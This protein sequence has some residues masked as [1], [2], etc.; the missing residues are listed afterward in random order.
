MNTAMMMRTMIQS[1]VVKHEKDRTGRT[2]TIVAL[3]KIPTHPL[4][5]AMRIPTHW[6]LEKAVK[7]LAPLEQSQ[8]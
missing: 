2:A 4:T 6:I 7:L 1:S 5:G 3:M 8:S